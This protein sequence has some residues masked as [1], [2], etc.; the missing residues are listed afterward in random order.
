MS[1]NTSISLGNGYLLMK[2]WKKILIDS[3]LL[4]PKRT[5]RKENLFLVYWTSKREQRE[6]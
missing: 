1:I 6:S 4:M 5:S 2:K 3:L